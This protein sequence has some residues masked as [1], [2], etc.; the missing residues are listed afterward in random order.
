MPGARL[1]EAAI[2]A[3]GSVVPGTI[4]AYQIASGNPAHPVRT[5]RIRGAETP[6]SMW[7]GAA[8]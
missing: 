4:S 1:E 3:A 2:C 6:V 5:R 8:R 7:N